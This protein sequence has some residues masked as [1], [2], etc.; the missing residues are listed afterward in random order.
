MLKIHK[1]SYLI[2][3]KSNNSTK[4][5]LKIGAIKDDKISIGWAQCPPEINHR[6]RKMTN[7]ELAKK[8]I[9]AGADIKKNINNQSLHHAILN[10]DS[11]SKVIKALIN[12]GA[13][14]KKY[15]K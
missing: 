12:A 7:S 13:D 11:N 5:K 2:W 10:C 14:I 3:K 4:K 1:D 6:D 9:E 15:Q 8:L